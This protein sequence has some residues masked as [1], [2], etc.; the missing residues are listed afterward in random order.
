V[1]GEGLRK[2]GR[3]K[4]GSSREMPEELYKDGFGEYTGAVIESVG[5]EAD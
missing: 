5:L 3:I 4:D 2:S 1:I